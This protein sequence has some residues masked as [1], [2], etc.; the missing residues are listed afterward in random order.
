MYVDHHFEVTNII[1]FRVDYLLYD[2]LAS[3]W[4]WGILG[5]KQRT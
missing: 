2:T 4:I 1:V 3:G 5:W